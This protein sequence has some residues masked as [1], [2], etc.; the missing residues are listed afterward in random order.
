M[1]ERERERAL[2]KRVKAR[3]DE[4]TQFILGHTKVVGSSWNPLWQIS[5]TLGSASQTAQFSVHARII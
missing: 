3:R 4:A 5:Q 1:K 2:C